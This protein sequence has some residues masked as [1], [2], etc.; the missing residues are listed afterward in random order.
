[1]S[2]EN[3]IAS[4]AVRD[5]AA[6]NDWYSALFARGA[7]STP[8]NQGAEWKFP[9]GGWLQVYELPERAGKGSV[10]MAVTDLAD[11]A[12]RIDSLAI[13]AVRETSSEQVRTLTIADPDGNQITFAEASDRTMAQ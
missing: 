6:A 12:A 5:M 13:T 11:I 3:A 4:L 10:T 7:D 2:I 8:M 9:R 1:M